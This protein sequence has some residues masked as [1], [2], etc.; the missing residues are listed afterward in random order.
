MS[1][2]EPLCIFFATVRQRSDEDNPLSSSAQQK[3]VLPLHLSHSSRIGRKAVPMNKQ[4]AKMAWNFAEWCC[5]NPIALKN[6]FHTHDLPFAYIEEHSIPC[7][8]TCTSLSARWI[9]AR[10][11]LF[12]STNASLEG[13]LTTS[14]GSTLTLKAPQ[15]RVLCHG[16]TCSLKNVTGMHPLTMACKQET[17]FGAQLFGARL[18]RAG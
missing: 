1:H 4:Q 3:S 11:V 6:A 13:R 10:R 5:M 12:C 17:V 7:H 2:H 15:S 18:R 9:P 16:C 14:S 8:L